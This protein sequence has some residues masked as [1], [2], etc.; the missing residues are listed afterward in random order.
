MIQILLK[1]ELGRVQPWLRIKLSWGPGSAPHLTPPPHPKSQH[2]DHPPRRPARSGRS[3]PYLAST[4]T[5]IF[6]RPETWVEQN[7]EP[8]EKSGQRHP[9][10][11][12]YLFSN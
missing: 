12:Y 5:L 4:P 8:E 10:L 6:R 3:P 2:P 9:P 11:P 7:L 1:E